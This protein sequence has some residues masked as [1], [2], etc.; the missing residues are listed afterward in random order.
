MT[1]ITWVSLFIS[2]VPFEPTVSATAEDSGGFHTEV[3]LIRFLLVVLSR[4]PRP[5]AAVPIFRA[6]GQRSAAV[7]PIDICAPTTGAFSMLS[8]TG[9]LFLSAW[10]VATQSLSMLDLCN[11]LPM[12]LNIQTESQ[13]HFVSSHKFPLCT[14]FPPHKQCIFRC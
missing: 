6:V 1:E 2:R 8:T 9:A 13:N 12:I 5:L 3:L 7:D 10:R 11:W 4:P 14:A